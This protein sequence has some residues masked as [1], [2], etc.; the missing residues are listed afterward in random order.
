M[1]ILIDIGNTNIVIGE[2][3]NEIGKIYRFQ[4]DKS[5]SADEYYIYLKDI[6]KDA[7][8]IIISSVVPELNKTFKNLATKYLNIEPLFVGAGV[9][10]GVQIIADNPKEAGADLVTGASGAISNYGDNSIVVDMGTATT[11]TLVLNKTIK[12]VVITSGLI[13]Q[14]NALIG[15]ASQLTQ[16]EFKTPTKILGTNTVDCLNSGLLYGHTFMIEKIVNEI[17]IQNNLDNINVII[18]GGASAL[19]KDLFTEQ[20]IFDD[21]LLLKGLVNIYNKNT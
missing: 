12:G 8:G 9:K 7:T 14:K 20:F 6:L 15:G 4:T 17:K 3:K 1:I 11:F 2:Y 10:T 19:L 21:L 16:F 5:K 13:T 18:T